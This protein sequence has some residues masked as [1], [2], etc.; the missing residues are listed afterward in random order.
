MYICTV[1]RKLSLTLLLLL[2]GVFPYKKNEDTLNKGF[3]IFKHIETM[4][5][6]ITNSKYTYLIE[7]MK[8]IT[9]L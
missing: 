3:H 2:V 7:T 9:C 6:T 4:K 8:E 1:P 5:E